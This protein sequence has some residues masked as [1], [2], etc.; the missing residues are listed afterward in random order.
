M[1]DTVLRTVL[2]TA[3]A[4]THSTLIE[5]PPGRKELPLTST[6]QERT[7]ARRSRLHSDHAGKFQ[8]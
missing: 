8:V 3:R 5:N 2:R 6:L 4:Q 7:E 1:L